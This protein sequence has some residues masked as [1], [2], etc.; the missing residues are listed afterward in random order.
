MGV[1]YRPGGSELQSHHGEQWKENQ[2]LKP[3]WAAEWD[4]RYLWLNVAALDVSPLLRA[5]VSDLTIDT[6]HSPSINRPLS[7]W[8]YMV[9]GTD[10]NKKGNKVAMNNICRWSWRHC[11]SY[12]SFLL[13]KPITALQSEVRKFNRSRSS[14]ATPWEWGQQDSTNIKAL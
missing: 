8:I 12:N 14:S 7:V 13:M 4:F 3:A 5:A 11:M 9:Y 2:G 1:Y 10:N 6:F